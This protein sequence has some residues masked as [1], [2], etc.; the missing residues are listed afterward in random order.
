M[1]NSMI[2]ASTLFHFTKTKEDLLNILENEFCPQYSAED[3]P[4]LDT[5]GSKPHYY[6]PMVCFS[7]IPLSRIEEH[8][9]FYGDYA[10]GLSKE[11]GRK[12]HLN[13]VLYLNADSFLSKAFRESTE[14]I[15]KSPPT[16]ANEDLIRKLIN[17]SSYTKRYEGKPWRKGKRLDDKRIFYNEKE[18]RYTPSPEEAIKIGVPL[19]LKEFDETKILAYQE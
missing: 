17:V 10:I 3:I 7:D 14:I 19:S 4:T 5:E 6:M 13:P 1:S 11:W 18:W 15:L 2:S 16:P 9:D 12:N 8:A